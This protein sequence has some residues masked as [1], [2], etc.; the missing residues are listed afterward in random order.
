MPRRAAPRRAA[1][2]FARA[3]GHFYRVAKIRYTEQTEFFAMEKRTDGKHE[4]YAKL[5]KMYAREHIYGAVGC[6]CRRSVS[7]PKSSIEMERSNIFRAK[8]PSFPSPIKRLLKSHSMSSFL[9][10]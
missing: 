2:P 10:I 5:E 8:R 3:A 1:S 4:C 9:Y 6:R 7:L